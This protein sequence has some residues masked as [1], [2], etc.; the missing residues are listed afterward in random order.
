MAYVNAH[1]LAGRV[2]IFSTGGKF[3]LGSNFMLLQALTLAACSYALLST[4]AIAIDYTPYD[5][6]GHPIFTLGSML[7]TRIL[8]QTTRGQT[9]WRNVHLETDITTCSH[10]AV[11]HAQAFC[12]Q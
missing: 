7:V 9:L 6:V 5:F 12:F 10:I 2:T 4:D 11:I 1:T 3:R 8:N